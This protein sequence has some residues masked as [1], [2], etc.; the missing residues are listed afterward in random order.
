MQQVD[1]EDITV[2]HLPQCVCVKKINRPFFKK[3]HV[4]ERQHKVFSSIPYQ[5]SLTKLHL[6]HY[7]SLVWNICCTD[8]CLS[9]LQDT[10]LMMGYSQDEAEEVIGRVL[11][12]ID[13]T[14]HFLSQT[15]AVLDEVSLKTVVKFQNHSLICTCITCA[16]IRTL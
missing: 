10:L 13:S 2:S 11:S 7:A 9:V 1:I 8:S 4:M 12:I 15:I 6:D 3:A 5:A 16:L 14:E